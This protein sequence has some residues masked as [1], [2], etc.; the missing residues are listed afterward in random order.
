VRDAIVLRE[1]LAAVV[2]AAFGPARR[3]VGDFPDREPMM[4]IVAFN[5]EQALAFV[6]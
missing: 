2:R 4:R 1:E 5:V 3:L 6:R